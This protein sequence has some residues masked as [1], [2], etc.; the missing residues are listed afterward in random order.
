M[1]AVSATTTP[2]LVRIAGKD[3]DDI[4]STR[5]TE[6]VAQRDGEKPKDEEELQKE[7]EEIKRG[8]ALDHGGEIIEDIESCPDSLYEVPKTVPPKLVREDREDLDEPERTSREA[9]QDVQKAF[10]GRE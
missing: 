10:D 7:V 6:L 9:D 2:K 1:R 5:D 3:A 4:P 8:R